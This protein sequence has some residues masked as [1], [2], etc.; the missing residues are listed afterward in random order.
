MR[1]LRFACLAAI[2][3][4]LTAQAP[5]VH[6]IL[7]TARQ[8]M[9]LTDL[10]ASGRLVWVQPGGTRV[11]YPI[12][13]KARWF[14]G[15][16]RV[17]A[18][19]GN[20]PKS[21]AS[22]APGRAK[23]THVLIEM[24]PSGQDEIWI[25]HPGDKSA[26]ILPF[27]KWNEGPLGPTFG[28]EDFLEQQIFWPGQTLVEKTK[29][30]VRDCDVIKSTPASADKT[31]YAEVKTWFD[32]TIDFPVYA[33]KT[34]KETGVVKEFTYYGLRR[35]GGLWAA[36]QIEMKSRGQGG[37][38]LLI[39]DRGTPKANLTLNDFSPAQLTHF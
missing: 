31:H 11:S 36:R 28:Y 3:P 19:L 6:A 33:E 37:S 21:G 39:F 24:R 29:F 8:R 15:V 12:T 2:I 9:E 25:A 26:S 34:V 18:E 13:I 16:L 30:G 23:A 14:P 22:A 27:D 35:E 10:S 32:S 4:A 1:V 17:K 20:G 38:T 5:D 7:A